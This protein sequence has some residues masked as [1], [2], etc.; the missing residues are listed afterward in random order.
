MYHQDWLMRQIESMTKVIARFIFKREIVEY[1]IVEEASFE[2]ANFLYRK[3][4]ELLNRGQINEGENILFKNLDRENLNYLLIGLEF[5]TRINKLSDEELLDANF[6]RGELK[7]GLEDL[8]KA[9]G[10]SPILSLIK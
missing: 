10:V 1:E 5:Y 8:G 9:Y 4:L 7:S 3:I 6:S 2:G